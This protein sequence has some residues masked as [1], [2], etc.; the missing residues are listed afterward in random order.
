MKH[1]ESICGTT[2]LDNR[3]DRLRQT[4][5]ALEA[6]IEETHK[7]IE[8]LE[9]LRSAA[10]VVVDAWHGRSSVSLNLALTRLESQLQREK[11]KKL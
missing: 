6:A 1:P 5:I 3:A 2:G 7:L 10:K 4:E 8:E 9:E 11:M